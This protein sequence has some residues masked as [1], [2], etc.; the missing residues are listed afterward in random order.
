MRTRVQKWDNSLALRIPKSSAV[1]SVMQA[2]PARFRPG[3]GLNVVVDVGCTPS[4]F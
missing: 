2:T 3:M 4:C 1:D